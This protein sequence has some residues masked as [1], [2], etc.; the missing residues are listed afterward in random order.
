M[1]SYLFQVIFVDDDDLSSLQHSDL[2]SARVRLPLPDDCC[3]PAAMGE[4]HV[5]GLQPFLLACQL[6]LRPSL[7]TKTILLVGF[8]DKRKWEVHLVEQTELI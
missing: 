8:L 3:E 2:R 7:Q 4:P 5:T 1:L 6:F